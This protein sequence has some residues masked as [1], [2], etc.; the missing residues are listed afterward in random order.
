MSEFFIIDANGNKIELG[1]PVDFDE[2]ITHAPS[3]DKEFMDLRKLMEPIELRLE[4]FETIK[5]KR[6]FQRMAKKHCRILRMMKVKAR[7]RM[8]AQIYKEAAEAAERRRKDREEQDMSGWQD[9]NNA[10]M[11]ILENMEVDDEH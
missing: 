11:R 4:I 5:T 8:R 10:C 6:F 7:W 9:F 3:D 2:I 1:A